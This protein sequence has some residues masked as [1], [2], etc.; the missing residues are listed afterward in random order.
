MHKLTDE[1]K[2][3]VVN[4]YLNH[5]KIKSIS[6]RMNVTSGAISSILRVRKIELPKRQKH[7]YNDRSFQEINTTDRAYWL[8]FLYA[9]GGLCGRTLHLT[10]GAVDKD[11]LLKFADFLSLKNPPLD[12]RKST[13]VWR[14]QLTSKNLLNDL[15]SHGC[16][17]RKTFIL[18]TPKLNADLY[19]HFYRGY[20]DGDGWYTKQRRKNRNTDSIMI[21][22][23]GA[24]FKF[25]QDFFTWMQMS[26]QKNVGSFFERKN[27]LWQFSFEGKDTV[28]KI[29]QLLYKN[30][31][32]YLERKYALAKQHL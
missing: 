14:L 24:S 9:D 31:T 21:G 12:Y 4:S 30:A 15:I 26:L 19:R 13:N 5:E 18:E 1:Q 2:I 23:S 8:G 25:M 27:K 3:D 16:V 10:L 6:G 11:H 32:T 29:S 17:R 7:F 28:A 22:C 20:I